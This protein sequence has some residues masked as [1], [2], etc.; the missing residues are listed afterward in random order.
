MKSLISSSCSVTIRV[1][2]H[3]ITPILGRCPVTLHKHMSSYLWIFKRSNREKY[4]SLPRT[5]RC[6]KLKPK[7]LT[8]DSSTPLFTTGLGVCVFVEVVWKISVLRLQLQKQPPC[9]T[10]NAFQMLTG[11]NVVSPYMVKEKV[12][13]RRKYKYDVSCSRGLQLSNGARM[14]SCLENT[15]WGHSNTSGEGSGN[16]GRSTT[17]TCVGCVKHVN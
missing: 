10:F 16:R 1:T 17:F 3:K 8:V 9:H 4:I 14:M 13:Q 12:P 15:L 7:F 6:P 5:Q 11:S 2:F